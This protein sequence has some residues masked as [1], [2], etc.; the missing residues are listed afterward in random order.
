M[1]CHNLMIGSEFSKEDIAYAT[2]NRRLLSM[3][4]ELGLQCN[5]RCQYCYLGHGGDKVNVLSGDEIRGAVSQAKA[6]GARKIILLGGEPMI[7]PGVMEILAFL[8]AEQLDVEIFTN[9]TNVTAENAMRMYDLGV[10]VVLKMNSF[11]ESVQD[12]LAGVKGAYQIIQEAYRN[13]REAGFPSEGHPMAVSTVIC[14]QN[15]PEIIEMWE[16]LRDQKIT[17]YFEIITPQGNAQ[18]NFHLAVDLPVLQ[19]LFH[20]LA[21][22]DHA[23]FGVRWEPQPPLVGDRCLRHQFS[24]LITA[25]GDVMPCVGVTIPVGNIRERP[26]ADILRDSEVVQDL[27]RYKD[28]IRG[29]CAACEKAESCYG[30][31]GAAYQMTGD[32]LASDPLCW[33]NADRGNEIMKLPVEAGRMIPQQAPMRL[34]ESLVSVG[35]RVAVVETSITKDNLFVNDDGTLDDIAYLELI[36]Q[37]AA[38][39]NGFRTSVRGGNEPEGYLLGARQFE[40]LEPARLG[41]TLRIRVFKATKFGDFGIIE[42]QVFRNETVLAKGEIKVWHKAA[43]T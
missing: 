39:M 12:E 18:D 10:Q 5:F 30:C 34:V 22:L 24:C 42:G 28:M 31:R 2:A 7:F 8:R 4:I 27:R 38:A 32:Y 19:K 20:E 16:W 23:R 9:G 43:C 13:L 41:D 25:R 40:V 36:A 26:L 17:P 1:S 21:D 35:D 14:N 15:L 37:A 33:R 29:P 11:K 3:E 6:I